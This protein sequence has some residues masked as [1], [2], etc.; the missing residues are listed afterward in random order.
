MESSGSSH[1]TRGRDPSLFVAPPLLFLFA[2]ALRALSL[3]LVYDGRGGVYFFGNDAYY[4]ARRIVHAIAHFPAYLQRDP[5]LNYPVGGEPIWPPTFDWLAAGAARVFVDTND[6]EAIERFLVWIPPVLGA[7]TVVLVYFL[8]RRFA[9][10]VAA[11]AAGLLLAILPAHVWYSQLAFVDHHVATAFMT[12]LLLAAGMLFTSGKSDDRSRSAAQVGHIVGLGLTMAGAL[13]VWPGSLLQVAAV[14]AAL[15]VWIAVAPNP[16][17]AAARAWRM[18]AANAVA[19]LAIAPLSLGNHWAL[20]GT[21]SPLVLSNFQPL[22]LGASALGF[23]VLAG[24]WRLVPGRSW[25]ERALHM[26]LAAAFCSGIVA[27][28]LPEFGQGVAAAW[29]WLAKTDAFQF[30]VR[31]SAPLLRAGTAEA[32]ATLSRLVVLFPLFLLGLAWQARRHRERAALGLLLGVA[33]VLFAATLAQARFMN[34]FSVTFAFVCGWALAELAAFARARLHGNRMAGATVLVA[35]SA[36]VLWMLAPL[37]TGLREGLA[38]LAAWQRGEAVEA[39]SSFHRTQRL[40]ESTAHWLRLHS[41]ETSGWLDADAQP[42]YSVL[43]PWS[44]GHV[45]KYEARRPVVQDNFGDDVAPRNFAAARAYYSARD[46]AK[47]LASLNRRNV[48]YVIV[49]G[50]RGNFER[51]PEGQHMM[52]RLQHHRGAGGSLSAADPRSWVPALSRHRLIFE[53]VPLSGRRGLRPSFYKIFE[54][55][56]GARIAGRAD[57][58]ARVSAR[59]S[60]EPR[61]AEAFEVVVRARADAQGRYTLRL[62]YANTPPLP[63]VATE[64]SWRFEAPGQRK[65]MAVTETMVQDARETFPG[66]DLRTRAH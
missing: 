51:V 60:V 19:A 35:A 37:D 26:L 28:L 8:V 61:Q 43:A 54:V 9:G 34:S 13:A 16:A 2:L 1:A 64:E 52:A 38:N 25:P 29:A 45:I 50:P 42:E 46:E 33:G 55:V 62:P 3:P 63:D 24:F 4:H 10:N 53:S 39:S 27:G 21:A 22:L 48:R 59:L 31:E 41:P 11:W 20:W 7:V 65:T 40:R 6:L 18:G 57:P 14:E 32:F 58:G 44:M 23:F 36:L 47:A 17:M 66:P 49:Q 15:T 30:Q 56:P 5:Y 12:T